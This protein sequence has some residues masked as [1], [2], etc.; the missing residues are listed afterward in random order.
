[1]SSDHLRTAGLPQKILE[2][3]DDLLKSAYSRVRLLIKYLKKNKEISTSDAY[4]A[5]QDAIIAFQHRD[6]DILYN[7]LAH[8]G[9]HDPYVIE[10]AVR[11]MRVDAKQNTCP[12]LMG[13]E[14]AAASAVRAIILGLVRERRFLPEE[15]SFYY[16]FTIKHIDDVAEVLEIM[17]RGIMEPSEIEPLLE[18]KRLVKKSL[19]GGAL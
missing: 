10:R 12:L 2:P 9:F 19:S 3:G 18:Q 6:Y 14:M 17:E 13:D 1:M 11:G 5:P 15:E 8:L 7:M 4:D 16:A